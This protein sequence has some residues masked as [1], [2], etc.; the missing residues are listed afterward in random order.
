MTRTG[1]P[2][3]GR[4]R[5]QLDRRRTQL[6]CPT[7]RP[8]QPTFPV[9]G[10]SRRATVALATRRRL[11]PARTAICALLLGAAACSAPA[12]HSSSPASHSSGATSTAAACE[13]VG[14]N[15]VAF[16]DGGLP[17]LVLPCLGTGPAVH[18][19]ALTGRPTLVNLWAAWCAPCREEMPLLEQSFRENG[20]RVRFLGVNTDDTRASAI[21]FLTA[22][23]V[24]YPQ[25]VDSSGKLAADL[26]L[27]GLPVTLA[28]DPSGRIIARQI[29][30][31]HPDKLKA[32]LRQLL[33]S[34]PATPTPG[35]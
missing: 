23:G 1:P 17:G 19:G 4:P 12:Q 29:G 15:G 20:A 13:K 25:A 21:D 35:K 27:P 33:A 9:Q 2:R 7:V 5:R 18:V 16:K 11:V 24:T 30:Q 8:A 34:T 28:L 32:L 10:N 14:P 6:D 31:L 22:T 3:R 26:G